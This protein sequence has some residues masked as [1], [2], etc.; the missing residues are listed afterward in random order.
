[1]V[2]P[3]SHLALEEGPIVVIEEWNGPY[4]SQSADE[5]IQG[6]PRGPPDGD[7]QGTPRIPQQT[8]TDA[9]R[10]F[11]DVINLQR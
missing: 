4:V 10:D 5:D 6:T 2:A 11:V 3:R 1:M 8:P 7:P 9:T